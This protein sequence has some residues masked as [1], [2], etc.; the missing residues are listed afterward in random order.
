MSECRIAV[1]DDW[2]RVARDVVEWNALAS[3]GQVDFLHDY[4][5][6]LQVMAQRLAPY[7]VLCVMRERTPCTPS[8]FSACRV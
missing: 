3:V 6:D 1:M 4:P 2:Q 8:C 7:T 5:A